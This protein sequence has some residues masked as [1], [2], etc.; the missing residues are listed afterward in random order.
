[1]QTHA[2]VTQ[3]CRSGKL[4]GEQVL[5]DKRTREARVH[6]SVRVYESSVGVV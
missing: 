6:V 5:T 2:C 4:V 1:M 3:V